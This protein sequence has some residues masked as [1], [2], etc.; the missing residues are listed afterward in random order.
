MARWKE[1]DRPEL[2]NHVPTRKEIRAECEKIQATWTRIQ[3]R[4]RTV[5]K[6]PPVTLMEVSTIGDWESRFCEEDQAESEKGIRTC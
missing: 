6:R 2:Q 4:N 3:R 1:G 5:Q